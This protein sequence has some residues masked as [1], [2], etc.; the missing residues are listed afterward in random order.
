MHVNHTS[1]GVRFHT[2]LATYHALSTCVSHMAIIPHMMHDKLH[3]TCM[4]HATRKCDPCKH[5]T[6]FSIV[7]SHYHMHTKDVII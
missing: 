7:V 6:G 1:V 4:L 5:V 2:L 3:E